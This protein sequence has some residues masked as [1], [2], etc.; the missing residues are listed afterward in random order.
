MQPGRYYFSEPFATDLVRLI[1]E[2]ENRAIAIANGTYAAPP[3][4]SGEPAT[5]K[6]IAYLRKLGVSNIPSTKREASTK[7]AALVSRR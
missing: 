1:R 5:T 3:D 2:S 7:I 4:K 6:Q